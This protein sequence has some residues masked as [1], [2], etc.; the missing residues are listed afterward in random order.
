[1]GVMERIGFGLVFAAGVLSAWTAWGCGSGTV[2]DAGFQ[3]RRD[4]HRLC[5][6]S[7]EDDV[8]AAALA[9]RLSG[10]L[11]A[12]GHGLNVQFERVDVEDASVSWRTDYGI[13][14][15]PPS[16]PAVALVGL[17]PSPRRAFVIDHWGAELSDGDLAVLAGSPARD[18]IAEHIVDAWAVLL[19]SP[20]LGGSDAKDARVEQVLAAVG[21]RWAREQPPG[22]SVVRFDRSDPRERILSSFVGLAASDPGWLGVVYGRGKLMAP[23]LRGEEISETHINQLLERLAVPC[24]CLQDSLVLGLDIPMAWDAALDARVA[25]TTPTEG[26]VEVT[27]GAQLAELE[28]EVPNEGQYVVATA[29]IPLG[30]GVFVAAGAVGMMLW[31][32][33]QLTGVGRE[34]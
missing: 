10:W 29:L 24:T 26:Y 21:A 28:T 7:E 32:R 2:R 5:L 20:A 14:S 3:G 4:M 6:F 31:R 34:C 1:M 12:A 9:A 13:P 22:V 8:E 18:A 27:L 30:V 17:F 15:A 25:A 11:E 16:L 33:R 19:Y 23:P